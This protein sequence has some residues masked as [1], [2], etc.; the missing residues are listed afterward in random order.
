MYELFN[1][2]S[3]VVVRLTPSLPQRGMHPKGNPLDPLIVHNF[4]LISLPS[5]GPTRRPSDPQRGGEFSQNSKDLICEPLVRIK[6]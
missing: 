5:E 3:V 2:Y 4:Q 6:F 1:K